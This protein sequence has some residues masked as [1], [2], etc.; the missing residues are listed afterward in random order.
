MPSVYVDRRKL[1]R[2]IHDQYLAPFRSRRA[3]GDVLWALARGL[4]AS[5]AHFDRLWRERAALA[6]IPTLVLWGMRDGAF[7]PS[8]LAR[9]R[10]VVPA[11]RVVELADAGHWPHEEEPAIVAREIS[12]NERGGV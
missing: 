8:M 7:R 6:D 4:H 2:A 3:R 9:W 11:A 1:T 10:E 12:G 5:A